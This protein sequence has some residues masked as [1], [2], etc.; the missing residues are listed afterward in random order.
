MRRQ[1]LLKKR[2]NFLS[3]R[4]CELLKKM[5]REVIMALGIVK[6]FNYKKRYGF[7]EPENGEGDIFVHI[8]ALR[9]ANINRLDEGQKIEYELEKGHNGKDCAVQLK[10]VS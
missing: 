9:E 6:W 3:Q 5:M 4:T 7:I 10:L 2:I 1:F 8:S